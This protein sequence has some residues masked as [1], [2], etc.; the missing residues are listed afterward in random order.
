MI[1]DQVNTLAVALYDQ[2]QQQGGGVRRQEDCGA[3]TFLKKRPCCATWPP[4]LLHPVPCYFYPW[5][6]IVGTMAYHPSRRHRPLWRTLSLLTSVCPS[7]LCNQRSPEMSRWDK[8]EPFP[9]VMAPEMCRGAFFSLSLS[10]HLPSFWNDTGLFSP[11][12]FSASLRYFF[13]FFCIFPIFLFRSSVSFITGSLLL[14][15]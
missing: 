15:R 10:F 4:L 11:F 6:L 1:V 7:L 9:T 12:I 3:S 13:F 8:W 14:L 5:L 2:L